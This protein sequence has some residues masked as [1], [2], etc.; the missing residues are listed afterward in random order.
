MK[1]IVNFVYGDVVLNPRRNRISTALQIQRVELLSHQERNTS[2]TKNGDEFNI[3]NRN[4]FKTETIRARESKLYFDHKVIRD[5][6]VIL[7]NVAYNDQRTPE[8]NTLDGC[9][10]YC[11]FQKVHTT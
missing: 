2:M 3:P 8:D 6:F 1:R 5:E 7:R 9:T 11:A 4:S 10:R